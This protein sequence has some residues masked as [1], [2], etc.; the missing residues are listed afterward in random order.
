MGKV[1]LLGWDAAD[2]QVI[3]PLLDRAEMPHLARLVERGVMG[4]LSTLEPVL[5]PMLWNS[6]A[7][8]KR[9]DKHGILGFIEPDPHTG[10]VR[11]VLSSSRRCKALWNILAQSGR[12]VHALNWF[13]SHP[14]EP[15]PGGVVVAETYAR[16]CHRPGGKPL[17]APGMV[18]PPRLDATMDELRFRAE[19]VDEETVALFVPR[20]A[21]IDMANAK[22]LA[23]IVRQ[24]AEMLTIHNAATYLAEHEPWDF[25]AVYQG[26]I[27]HFSH[28]FMQFHPPRQEWVAEKE[29]ALYHDVVNSAYRFHDLMLGRLV[30]LAGPETT[31]LLVSDHGFHSGAGRTPEVIR[32]HAGPAAQHRPHGIFVMAGP[33][34]R[35]DE[36]IYGAG[37]LDIAPTVL[38]LFGLPVGMD[39]EGRVLAEAF[40]KTPEIRTVPTWE[41]IPGESGSHATDAQMD[42]EDAQAMLQQFVALGYIEPPSPD[43][44]KA[45]VD[46]VREQKWN[47][48]RVHLSVGRVTEAAPLL[49]EIVAA[50][51]ERGDYAALLAHCQARLGLFDE[52]QRTLDTML[53]EHRTMPAARAVLGQ[54]ARVQG[55]PAAALEHLLVAAQA[56]DA[57]ADIYLALARTYTA[58]HRWE[59]AARSYARMIEVDPSEGLAHQGLAFVLLRLRRWE[60]AAASAL[61]AVGCQFYLPLSHYYLGCALVR[62]GIED[63]AIQAFEVALAQR[64]PV[65]QAH[66]WLANLLERVPARRAEAEQHRQAWHAARR[67]A[68]E[69]EREQR[70]R[71]EAVRD[72]SKHQE[73]SPP[74]R[75]VPSPSPAVIAGVSSPE[76]APTRS[77][78][79]PLHGDSLDLLLVS[80]LPRSGTS[81]M[82]QILAAGGW[83]LLTDGE[84]RQDEDNPEGYY[85][86][87]PAKQLRNH[88]ELIRQADGMVLKAVSLLL[89]TLPGE[90]RYR[91]IFMVRP[92]EQVAESQARM[93]ARRKGSI[94]VAA[95][96][97]LMI[98]RLRKHLDWT[99][100]YLRHT[101][102]FEVLEVDYPG[103]VA[104]P[105]VWMPKIA[106]FAGRADLGPQPL[107]AML[108]CVRAELYRNRR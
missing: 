53:A 95:G 54:L 90:H 91:I 67:Q 5:S 71:S 48:A 86:W 96:R 19:E 41:S 99:R 39:M 74:L 31:I 60:E 97:E 27:D 82:M 35:S 87:E 52:A 25:M 56:P 108:R 22:S 104:D 106:R 28:A 23:V 8:G 47:L 30:E 79:V 34:V 76:P 16:E 102:N 78:R 17:M 38:T 63:R 18:H 62:L 68:A 103:L 92:V 33:G 1:L 59:D 55:Q 11:P 88:P 24:I 20:A 43:K 2:W 73:Q 81:M 50:S 21:E 7:T 49:E 4:D 42:Q 107:N 37:L 80:G 32:V 83:S 64:P 93:I 57:P 46:A 51:P 13:A 3:N 89:P 36:R 29:F 14:A 66:R 6:I 100:E 40:T 15:L 44:A 72:R 75:T 61:S 45:I 58:L 69:L 12:R 9:A 65:W 85:E 101:S 94:D 77:L 70:T 84:R 105:A 26:A 98:K 10:N